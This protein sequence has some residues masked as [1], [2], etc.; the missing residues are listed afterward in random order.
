MVR[1]HPVEPAAVDHLS[2]GTRDVGAARRPDHGRAR[3]A[4]CPLHPH[5]LQPD[6]RTDDG[7]H[8]GRFPLA[9]RPPDPAAGARPGGRGGAGV[10]LLGAGPAFRPGLPVGPGH[11]AAAGASAGG[12]SGPTGPPA[13]AGPGGP[14][15]I[16]P[17]PAGP[18]AIPQLPG[19]RPRG[20][21][22]LVHQR[23]PR[24]A[25]GAPE[26]RPGFL[27]PGSLARNAVARSARAGAGHDPAAA[28]GDRRFHPRRPVQVLDVVHLADEGA[29]PGIHASRDRHPLEP[30]GHRPHSFPGAFHDGARRAAARPPPPRPPR[31]A[32]RHVG[33]ARRPVGGQPGHRPRRGPGRRRHLRRL[34]SLPVAARIRADPLRRALPRRAVAARARAVLRAAHPGQR[35]AA[36]P[37]AD[38]PGPATGP[39]GAV[40]RRAGLCRRAGPG[41]TASRGAGGVRAAPDGSA[42]APRPGP[43]RSALRVRRP[44]APVDHV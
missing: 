9:G 22:L 17:D 8:H 32:G 41:A 26:V 13:A 5:R 28:G 21:G 36:S 24:L 30:R 23:A 12:R 4:A 7:V 16:H 37:G 33:P 3:R 25:R 6:V 39:R 29:V 10:R 34:G 27:Q 35:L 20:R 18:L 2:L 19:P 1:G 14:G 11:R 43:Y 15:H 42:G 40:A 44:V 38:S 31:G